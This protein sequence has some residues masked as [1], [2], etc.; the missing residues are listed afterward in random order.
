LTS[1][2]FW[3][4]N[5]KIILRPILEKKKVKTMN[6]MTVNSLLH[7]NIEPPTMIDADGSRENNEFD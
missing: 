4:K 7:K 1:F 2:R 6:K 5:N 3:S